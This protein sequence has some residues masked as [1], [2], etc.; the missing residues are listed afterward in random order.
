MRQDARED[1]ATLGELD[2]AVEAAEEGEAQLLLEAVDCRLTA[3]CVTPS[4]P[5][6]L[7][8]LRRRAAASSTTS[9]LIEGRR[10]RNPSMSWDYA[11]TA[12][13]CR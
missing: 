5:A 1:P 13:K 9:E 7:V 8:K 12:G 6:A 10:R 3:A 2:P 4:S 11:N